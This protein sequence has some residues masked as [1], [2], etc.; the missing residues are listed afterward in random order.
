MLRLLLALLL[1]ANV[2]F[3]GWAL[4]W[5][6]P[7]L[8]PPGAG[9]REPGRSASQVRPEAVVVLE[10]AAAAAATVAARRAGRQCLEAGPFGEAEVAAAEAAL[11]AAGL[12]AG[13][14]Q[15]EQVERGPSWV[16]F[17]GRPADATARRAREAELRRAGLS[18]Q[19]VQA[20]P[21]IAGGLVVSRPA[22]ASAAAAAL[23]AL[24]DRP[25]RRLSI[26]A[27]PAPPP[28]LW[29]RVPAADAALQARLRDADRGFR[30]CPARP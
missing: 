19:V 21:E 11:V 9:D 28:Q 5:L 16:L 6:E 10:P 1:T 4:G 18:Y 3:L 20:P 24:A 7:L 22:C 30:P 25:L 17:A 14:W 15:R 13:S 2:L 26:V 27:L 29:L 8:P 12:A 23:A